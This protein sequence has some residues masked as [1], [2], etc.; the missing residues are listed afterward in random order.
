MR[1][2]DTG[3]LKRNGYLGDYLPA[4]PKDTRRFLSERVQIK[5]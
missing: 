5:N 1:D 4:L 3:K 2:A